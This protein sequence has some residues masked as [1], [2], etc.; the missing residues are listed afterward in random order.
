MFDIKWISTGIAYR[1]GNTVYLNKVLREDKEVYDIVL[2]HELGHSEEGYSLKDAMIDTEINPKLIYFCLKHPSTWASLI[3]IVKLDDEW[4][5]DIY[6]L[7]L[8]LVIFICSI[9]LINYF[10]F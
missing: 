8:Y 6:T 7:L 5:Y 1:D 10:F 2:K 3:P 9:V 4:C